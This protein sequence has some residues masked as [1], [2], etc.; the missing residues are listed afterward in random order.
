MDAGQEETRWSVRVS[1]AS[2]AGGGERELKDGATK[3]GDSG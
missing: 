3:A 2:V 1:Q